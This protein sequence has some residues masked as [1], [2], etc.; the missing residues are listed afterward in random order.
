[1]FLFLG[2]ENEKFSKKFKK[3]I[4]ENLINFKNNFLP[5]TYSLVWQ[6]WL[7]YWD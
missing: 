3:M 5:W 7:F 2:I 1:M 4:N 6:L